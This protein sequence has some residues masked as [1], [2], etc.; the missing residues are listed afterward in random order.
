MGARQKLIVLNRGILLA[1]GVD[2]V[3]LTGRL[4]SVDSPA[5]VA[6]APERY[7]T[8]YVAHGAD[9]G[10]VLP[11]P[12]VCVGDDGVVDAMNMHQRHM[13]L[14]VTGSWSN[15]HGAS[16]GCDG[17]ETMAQMTG[18][19]IGKHGTQGVADRIQPVRVNDMALGDVVNDVIDVVDV[20]LGTG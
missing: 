19:F 16:E 15:W 2:R 5:P 7:K 6:R 11:I 10:P 18:Q 14:G 8:G 4:G 13:A 3:H 12:G 17:G 9:S 1:L 20:L